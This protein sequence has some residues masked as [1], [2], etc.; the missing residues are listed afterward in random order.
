[1]RDEQ[2]LG[3]RL[4]ETQRAPDA[5]ARAAHDGA[6]A[7]Y[8]Q[9][10][11][12]T[13]TQGA[14]QTAF[15]YTPQLENGVPQDDA[16]YL[17][18]VTDALGQIT[19]FD[20]DLAGRVL[21]QLDAK[22]TPLA[23]LTATR[24]DKSGNL[25]GVTPPGQP[26]HL[27]AYS[28]VNTLSQYTAPPASGVPT[29]QTLYDI[30]ADRDPL[31]TTLPSGGIIGRTYDD[32][33]GQLE[34]V[35]VPNDSSLPPGRLEYSYYD[36]TDASTGKAAGRP[37][38]IRG[39]YGVNLDLWYDG[40]LQTKEIWSGNISGS[41][42]Y[43]YN[44]L[45]LPKRE[46]VTPG[47]GTASGFYFGYDPDQLLSCVSLSAAATCSPLATSDLKLTRSP[48][49][50]QVT[51]IRIGN[52]V[53]VIEYSDPTVPNDPAAFGELRRQTATY[54]GVT[55]ALFDIVYDAPTARRDPLG[56]ITFKAEQI[57]H[58]DLGTTDLRDFEF[59]YDARNRL[60]RSLLSE[61]FAESEEIFGYDAN[62]NRDFYDE[63][64]APAPYTGVYDDQ[65]RLLS[66][67][68]P[69]PY[70][71]TTFTYGPNGEIKTRKQGSTLFLYSYDALGNLIRVERRFG[72]LTSFTST[73]L[74][75][76]VDAKGRRLGRK[77]N[78]TL[79]RAWLYR[80]GLS[81][82]AELD[83][84][85]NL[86]ARFIYG[87]R[88][89]IPDLVLRGGKTYRLLSDHLGSPRLAINVSDPS[90][91]PYRADYSAFGV[92]NIIKGPN[93]IPF[94]FAGGLYDT[95][96]Q[97]VRFGARDYDPS[98]GRW[99]SKDP[100][101]FDGGVNLYVYA[102]NDPVNKQDPAGLWPW[103]D[104]GLSPTE[105][106]LC[107]GAVAEGCSLGCWRRYWNNQPAYTLCNALCYYGGRVAICGPGPKPPLKEPPRCNP[108]IECCDGSEPPIPPGSEWG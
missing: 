19:E 42:T 12:A 90:D 4:A 66:Y 73:L 37:S 79:E 78:G 46:L 20:R 8:Q 23:A 49:H 21:T 60:Q 74:E 70:T 55:P 28:P 105:T 17:K 77:R 35:V 95:T 33:T 2:R 34:T 81:P 27:L 30:T 39:P 58:P 5:T 41:V 40:S 51:E 92:A 107:W 38:Q 9:G 100:V 14:R 44:N 29:S 86:V 52:V 102:A 63:T 3:G 54:T 68:P 88:P 62:G 104:P 75:Y 99:V 50:G 11:L 84:Q 103:V 31:R 106:A 48:I 76:L 10:R 45:F 87:S 36:T 85:G 94:G 69:A 24:W 47:I 67:G 72:T 89:N 83:A 71:P 7:F 26:E 16:G 57:R 101:R 15:G 25:V 1:V 64:S 97:L 108:A 93:W 18:L 59:Q 53:E 32:V 65:D 98:L 80:D 82:I 91:I 96:T 13:Q 61:P 22:Q 56:R 6:H 43:E